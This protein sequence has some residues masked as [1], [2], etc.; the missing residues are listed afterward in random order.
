MPDTDGALQFGRPV[1]NPYRFFGFLTPNR[2]F[3]CIENPRV[4]GSIP[5]LATTSNSMIYNGFQPSRADH[6]WA[7]M[8]DPRT[9]GKRVMV[10]RGAAPAGLVLH[11]G[12]KEG[13]GQA[14]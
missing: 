9:I 13:S 14:G 10:T 2:A 7:S 8:A 4:D 5:S 12:L 11:S 3:D 6:P 1:E